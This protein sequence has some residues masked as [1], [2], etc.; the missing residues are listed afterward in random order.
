MV[1]A[2]KDVDLKLVKQAISSSKIYDD[3]LERLDTRNAHWTSVRSE[4]GHSA[5]P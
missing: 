3:I 5:P 1:Y 2:D 4:A